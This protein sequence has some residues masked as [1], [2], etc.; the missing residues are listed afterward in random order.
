[1]DSD[2]ENGMRPRRPL[3]ENSS[4][5]PPLSPAMLEDTVYFILGV[6]LSLLQPLDYNR[7]LHD[8]HHTHNTHTHTH[9]H[10]IHETPWEVLLAF[11]AGS[12]ACCLSPLRVIYRRS[13]STSLYSSR[14]DT[15]IENSDTH[16][17]VHCM[18]EYIIGKGYLTWASIV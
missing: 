12:S 8:Q 1:M 3:V 11:L 6:N 7:T 2:R 5:L 13:K 4:C 16:M 9:T 17:Y 14:Y 15:Q 10:N 18:F